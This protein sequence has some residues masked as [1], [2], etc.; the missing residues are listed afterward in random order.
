MDEGQWACPSQVLTYLCKVFN[1]NFSSS[2]CICQF[3]LFIHINVD[4]TLQGYHL[5]SVYANIVELCLDECRISVTFPYQVHFPRQLD[6][7]VKDSC[8]ALSVENHSKW[9]PVPSKFMP[10]LCNL[11]DTKS[12]TVK[13]HLPCLLELL[14]SWRCLY[15]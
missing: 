1:R 4:H 5:F 12:L 8:V 7:G 6:S 11:C 9:A 3:R 10:T 14:P 15:L 2:L 13:E